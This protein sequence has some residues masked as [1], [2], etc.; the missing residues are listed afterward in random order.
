[1]KIYSIMILLILMRV[2]H[3]SEYQEQALVPVVSQAQTQSP[4]LL[5]TRMKAYPV[6]DRL[7]TLL[8]PNRN[9]KREEP[10][11][12]LVRIEV[13]VFGVKQIGTINERL[14]KLDNELASW[15]IASY[16]QPETKVVKMPPPTIIHNPSPPRTQNSNYSRITTPIIQNI[17]R[18][19]I[20]AIFN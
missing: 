6:L 2:V 3:A 9:F 18:R 19:S 11:A 16:A 13:A 10:A 20:D 8:Y 7:E 17:A 12:R 5:A 1:M 4:R 14:Q 15:Q